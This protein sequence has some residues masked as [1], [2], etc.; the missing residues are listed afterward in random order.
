MNHDP[1][2]RALYDN[3]VGD[4]PSGAELQLAIDEMTQKDNKDLEDN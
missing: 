2:A 3:P 4:R 1:Y